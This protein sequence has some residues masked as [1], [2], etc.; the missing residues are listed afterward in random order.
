MKKIH[1]VIAALCLAGTFVH[2]Q[3]QALDSFIDK[4]KHDEAFSFAFLS[5]DMFEAA[6]EFTVEEKDWKKLH[7]VVRN[8]GSL[9][10]LAADSLAQGRSLFREALGCVPRESVDELLTVRDGQEDVRIWVREEN[11]VVS[12][13]ILL[14]G[15]PD[16]FV[17]ICFSGNLELNNLG[18]LAQL[19]DAES[20][21]DLARTSRALAPEFRLSPNPSD[22]A[23]LLSCPADQGLPTRMT[24]VD[25]QGRLLLT[26]NL[27]SVDSQE[28]SLR[29]LPAGLYW[30]Q[31]ETDKGRIGAKQVQIVR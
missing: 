1:L 31:L 22:G 26:H 16:E 20:A 29:E 13:L 9:R 10:I 5:K 3:Q 23:F 6:T 7:N 15:S 2:A 27:A 21:E 4:Y 11:A 12:D 25:A 30:I 19:F 18:E 24:V 8:I 28:I 14:V 17:L